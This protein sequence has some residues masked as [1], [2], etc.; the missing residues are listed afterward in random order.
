[1][2]R[3][4]PI[5]IYDRKNKMRRKIYS[6]MLKKGQQ[7]S[8]T[9]LCDRVI[10]RKRVENKCH[11]HVQKSRAFCKARIV[12]ELTLT[13]LRR[14]LTESRFELVFRHSLKTLITR[15]V[16]KL[17]PREIHIVIYFQHTINLISTVNSLT[18]IDYKLKITWF[19]LT[20]TKNLW[21]KLIKP[22]NVKT[23]MIF[24]LIRI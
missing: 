7:K 12:S 8:S 1:M 6:K 4:I 23:E 19:K 14:A 2:G 18:K 3:R 16:R 15:V 20:T 9:T 5:D 13:P 11:D 22:K 24:S 17:Y 21:T 10:V